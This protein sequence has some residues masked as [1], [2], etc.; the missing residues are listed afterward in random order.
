MFQSYK[1]LLTVIIIFFLVFFLLRLFLPLFL[2][3]LIGAVLAIAA[4]PIVR[5]FQEKLRFSRVCA[6][7]L[8]LT[9]ALC[10]L[11]VT[12][13]LLCGLIIRQL[14][15][16]TNILPTIEDATHS[17][18]CLLQEKLLDLAASAPESLCDL[19]TSKVTD[20]FSDS[21]A[22]LE[23]AADL[24]LNLA[25]GILG[26]VPDSAFGIGTTIISSYMISVKLPRIK[27]RLTAK[28]S[29][30]QPWV[31]AVMKFRSSLLGWLKA[32]VKLSTITFLILMLGFLLL[33]IHPAPLWA[34]GIALVDAFPVLGTGTVLIPWSILVFLQGNPVLAVGLIGLYLTVMVIR[35][36]LEPKLLGRQ[37]GL[38]PLLTLVA[39]YAGYRIWGLLGMILAPILTVAASQ[40]AEMTYPRKA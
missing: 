18:M 5:F 32:Q 17:G 27:T 30:Y 1:K 29:A 35:S 9:L 6:A 40:I 4:E 26:R 10:L 24:I 38:D 21:S 2:P 23:Q 19:I 28:L 20:F 12:V 3:F 22:I 25:S 8:G 16:L 37:L 36:V 31:D 33:R 13:M 14:A 11:V 39:L 15:A 34:F 7:G